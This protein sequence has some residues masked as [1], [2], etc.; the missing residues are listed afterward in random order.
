MAEAAH[1]IGMAFGQQMNDL[2]ERT[3]SDLHS[4]VPPR[5]RR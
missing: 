1:D 5:R 4:P 3:A 2:M